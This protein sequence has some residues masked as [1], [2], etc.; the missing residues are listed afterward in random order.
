MTGTT[1]PKSRIPNPD[2]TEVSDSR[3]IQFY[4]SHKDA[5][6]YIGV[7][8]AVVLALVVLIN[9]NKQAKEQQASV[10]FKEAVDA[11][12][13]RLNSLSQA[14]PESPDVP[15]PVVKDPIAEIQEI[16]D[17]YPNTAASANASLLKAGVHIAAGQNEEALKVYSDWI[18]SHAD[19]AL[20][21]GAMLGKAT[22]E[23][24][25][26]RI[27]ESL[28]TLQDIQTKFPD[29]LLMDI[30]KFE[31]GKR[32]ESLENWEAAKQSYQEVIDRFPDST[33]QSLS[34]TK[35]AEIDRKHPSGPSEM[36]NKPQNG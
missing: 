8:V 31:T 24:N 6:G 32:F 2:K 16:V 27:S 25:L 18:T 33:W 28:K 20:V 14:Q 5:I 3:F 30:V 10:Q 34:Q 11:Y 29:F 23:M 12:Q 21:P 1:Q 13:N 15:T 35:I 4:Q 36:Q 7:A 9:M 17:N 19:H 26:D 22:A